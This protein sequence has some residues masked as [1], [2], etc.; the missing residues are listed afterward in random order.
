MTVQDFQKELIAEKEKI[1]KLAEL[2]STSKVS[3][4]RLWLYI[5][6]F[7]SNTVKT[8]QD[9]HKKEVENLLNN[10]RLTG[11]EFYRQKI[12]NFRLGHVFNREQL[13]YADGYTDEEIAQAKIIKRA[14]V[15]VVLRSGRRVL[16]VKVAQEI[17]G[18]LSK[19]D[20]PTMLQIQEYVF[21]N[22]AAGTNIEYFSADADEL[23]LTIDVYYDPLILNESGALLKASGADPIPEAIDAFLESENFAFNGELRISELTDVLQ[24]V[25]GVKDRSVKVTKAEFNI[26]EPRN[27]IEINE[28]YVAQAGYFE[29]LP[30]HLTINY[31]AKYDIQ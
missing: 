19:I 31:I 20:T 12:L 6:A 26:E 11:L 1:A 22:S 29:I 13:V 30:E 8:L 18:K 17:N 3:I 28:S 16:Y 14:S 23:R 24:N 5:V 15:D 9:I 10:Q 2:N 7:V 21:A 27:W 25:V 4:W